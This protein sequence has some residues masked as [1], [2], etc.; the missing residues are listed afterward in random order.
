[1]Q[2]HFCCLIYY[3]MRYN[4]FSFVLLSRLFFTLSTK[5]FSKILT[6]TYPLSFIIVDFFFALVL[7]R[8]KSDR[9]CYSF[10]LTRHRSTTIIYNRSS[11]IF[12]TRKSNKSKHINDEDNNHSMCA[13]CSRGDRK[14]ITHMRAFFLREKKKKRMSAA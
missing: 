4:T 13:V 12:Y 1:M 7:T 3:I 11:S 5:P 10:F 14:E 8:Q 6:L 9:L 2:T